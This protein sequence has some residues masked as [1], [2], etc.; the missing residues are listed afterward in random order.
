MT[1]GAVAVGVGGIAAGLI[2]SNKQSNAAK[3]AANAQAN[4][5]D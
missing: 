5:A 1:W 4:A 3:S 2:S